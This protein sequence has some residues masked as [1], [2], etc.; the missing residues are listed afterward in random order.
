MLLHHSD[1]TK[2]AT[3]VLLL[4]LKLILLLFMPF[5]FL[6]FN[7]WTCSCA[8]ASLSLFNSCV[9]DCLLPYF[10]VIAEKESAAASILHTEIKFLNSIISL[11][12][13]TAREVLLVDSRLS[14]YCFHC[15]LRPAASV[16]SV[17]AW[18]ECVRRPEPC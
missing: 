5:F 13:I 4:C 17:D 18:R 6:S 9:C 3:V 14:L 12:R 16:H 1:V 2:W 15:L 10:P 7:I 11:F 8:E